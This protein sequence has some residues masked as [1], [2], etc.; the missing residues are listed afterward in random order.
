[1]ATINWG[2]IGCGEVCE[3]K[4][5]PAFQKVPGSQLA[6]VMRRN[7]E[8]AADFARRHGVPRSYNQADQLINDPEVNAVYIATPP[9]TH[10][11][12]TL[13]A[14]HAGKPVYVEKPMALSAAAAFRM[15]EASRVLQ[16]PLC[17][18]HYRRQQPQYLKVL[19]LLRTGAIGQV[20]NVELKFVA[21]ASAYDTTEARISW[22]VN[23]EISGG[24]IFHDLAPH[25]LDLMNYFFGQPKL[26]KGMA[27]NTAGQYDP[28]D[29]L[30]AILQFEENI[31]LAANWFFAAPEGV[32]E[33]YC[34]INGSNGYLQFS[35]FGAPGITWLHD[36][37]VEQIPFYPL[38]HVQE[39]MIAAVTQFFLGN[40]A[41]P[42]PPAAGVV[43]MEC[44][45]KIAGA[46]E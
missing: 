33:D 28:P 31:L 15:Q 37:A 40:G 7:G 24:G 2:I 5:G 8:K 32:K 26:V 43:V 34:R 9:D 42:C 3:V 39:P 14:L 41:N 10:E 6:A 38:M 11:A 29:T 22:R 44:M 12:Y 17:V 21:P 23:P 36:G 16:V 46:G 13:A 30:A 18:A 27:T 19:E 4:S 25:Q 45:E 20:R 35:I 1:M